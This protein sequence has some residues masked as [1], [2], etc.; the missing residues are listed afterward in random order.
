M[1]RVLDAYF[2]F[3]QSGDHFLGQL[4][5]LKNPNSLDFDTPCPHWKDSNHPV[6]L[7]VLQLSFGKILLAHGDT[8]HD[9]QGVLSL[10]MASMVHH[11]SWMLGVLEKS[12]SHDF[13]KLALLNSPLLQELKVN[14]LTM[15]L[16]EHVPFVTGIPPHVAHMRKLDDVHDTCFDIKDAVVEFGNSIKETV[17]AAIDKMVENDGGIITAILDCK[18][19][20]FE[21]RIIQQID[22]VWGSCNTI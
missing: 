12:P 4:L 6:V 7:E 11:S 17:H 15:E 9:P 14:H 3:A 18:L 20:A 8:N 10:L 13:G 19:N 16:N 22:K 5:S 21:A 2:Q 1:G